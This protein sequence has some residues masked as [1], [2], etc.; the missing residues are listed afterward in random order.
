MSGKAVVKAIGVGVIALVFVAASI[1]LKPF[2]P[3]AGD[4][5][6]LAGASAQVGG[7][8][9]CFTNWTDALLVGD[10]TYGVATDGGTPVAWRPGFTARR[11]GSEVEVLAPDGDVVAVSGKNYRLEGAQ[12][13]PGPEMQGWPGLAVRVFWACGRVTER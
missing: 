5:P 4:V 13:G 9:G 12:V 7:G 1:W 3:D 10:P 6:L 11:V 2:L 8:G